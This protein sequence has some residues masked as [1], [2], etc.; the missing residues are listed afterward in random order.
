M[1]L[2][3]NLKLS[4]LIFCF[5]RTL[6]GLPFTSFFGIRYAQEPSGDLFLQK[7]VPALPWNGTFVADDEV[8]CLQVL[9]LGDYALQ[10]E[11]QRLI[12]IWIFLSRPSSILNIIFRSFI[13][14][15]VQ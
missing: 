10:I 5:F 8:T 11:S 12:Q 1:I 4:T 2:Y 7:P 13:Y 14:T 15:M 9:S 3:S 6:N